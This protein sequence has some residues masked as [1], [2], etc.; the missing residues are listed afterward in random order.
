MSRE[1]LGLANILEELQKILHTRVALNVSI[2][3]DIS[4]DTK[5][6]EP[7]GSSHGLEENGPI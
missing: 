1:G 6:Q 4:T 2:C 5:Q 3:A 7:R